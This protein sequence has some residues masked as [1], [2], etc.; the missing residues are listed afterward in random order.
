MHFL[1][2]QESLAVFN[3][4]NS[5]VTRQFPMSQHFSAPISPPVIRNA[6]SPM[7]SKALAFF[8]IL[9]VWNDILS[10]STRKQATVDSKGYRELLAKRDFALAFWDVA[11]CDSWILSAV[12]DITTLD[13]WKREEECKGKLSIRELANRAGTIESTIEAHIKHLAE[14]LDSQAA[15]TDAKP[16]GKIDGDYIRHVQTNILAHSILIE[17][18]AIVSGH[19]A[20]VPEINESIDRAILA[21]KRCPSSMT[22][23]CFV[24]SFCV[25]A[26][27]ATGLQRVFF[28][29]VMLQM[30]LADKA[31][32]RLHNVKLLV[33]KC[34]SVFD[35]RGS[36]RDSCED[37]KD[38]W[39]E[40]NMS[41]PF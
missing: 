6:P 33:E 8:T 21:W 22:P 9:L 5:P 15:S 10:S 2:A 14:L 20:G 11:E 36:N 31:L 17:L 39:Q 37:W 4:R 35:R 13:I 7:E 24:W 28:Q 3:D 27:L 23:R 40:M 34:W 25:S 12:M 38:I 29:E 26:N 16:P 18:H 32:G 41:I 19:W 1:I 30:T